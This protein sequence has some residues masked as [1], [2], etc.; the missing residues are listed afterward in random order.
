M[1]AKDDS[2]EIFAADIRRWTLMEKKRREKICLYSH[3][4][5]SI[6]Q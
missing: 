5:I 1:R 4:L 3:I 2:A 6:H